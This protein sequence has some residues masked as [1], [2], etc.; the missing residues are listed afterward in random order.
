MKMK[1]TTSYN[2]ISASA[3]FGYVSK[4]ITNEIW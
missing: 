1:D 4:M 3:S 2:L